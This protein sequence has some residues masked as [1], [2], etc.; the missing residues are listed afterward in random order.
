MKIRVSITNG[1][2]YDVND[3]KYYKNLKGSHM[4]HVLMKR[5]IIFRT[6]LHLYYIDLGLAVCRN[7]WDKEVLVHCKAC[8]RERKRQ[9][10]A[11]HTGCNNV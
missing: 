8:R 11:L 5:V 2:L 1:L 7:T 6:Y 3:K 9:C 10:N 4:R